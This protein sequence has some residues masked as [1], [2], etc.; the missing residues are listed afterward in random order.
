MN[1]QKKDLLCE[2]EVQLKERLHAASQ[3]EHK[4]LD[5]NDNSP[6]TDATNNMIYTSVSEVQASSSYESN[7]NFNDNDV[8]DDSDKVAKDTDTVDTEIAST[9]SSN[10]KVTFASGT[11]RS[12]ITADGADFQ[13]S[14]P[15][16][17]YDLTKVR[18]E[19]SQCQVDLSAEK[20]LRKKKERNLIKT[21]KQIGV[22]SKTVA[23]KENMIAEVSICM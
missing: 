19:L 4:S 2:A 16:L 20:A 7:D 13:K 21:V 10:S 1:P 9:T 3:E 23:Q 17:L 15:E 14:S 18:N 8:D 11:K 12:F 5:N 22:I 6:T